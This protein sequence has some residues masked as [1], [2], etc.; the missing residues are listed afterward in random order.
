MPLQVD[1][2]NDENDISGHPKI[3]AIGESAYDGTTKAT[4]S[5]NIALRACNKSAQSDAHS[6]PELVSKTLAMGL[7]PDESVERVRLGLGA[8]DER[9]HDFRIISAR[10]CS[11]EKPIGP[12]DST[13]SRR[14]SS[15]ARCS[16]ESGNASKSILAQ[17]SSMSSSFSSA[18]RDARFRAGFAMPQFARESGRRQREKQT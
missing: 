6:I 3:D 17:R 14:R 13:R 15:S 5:R 9:L 2:A 7:V 10:T 16:G 12:S 18:V 11:Q 1:D 8:K 4:V